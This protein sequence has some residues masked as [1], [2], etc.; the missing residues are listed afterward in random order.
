MNYYEL[1]N[2]EPKASIFEI[3]KAYRN[4]IK[5]YHSDVCLDDTY[6]YQLNEA[7]SVLLDPEKRKLYDLGV[8]KSS[9]KIPQQ[10]TKKHNEIIN[11]Y[12]VWQFKGL[13]VKDSIVDTDFMFKLSKDNYMIIEVKFGCETQEVADYLTEIMTEDFK[14]KNI[15]NEGKYSR[16]IVYSDNMLMFIKF[17][18]VEA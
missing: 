18:G 6:H 12:D 9:T 11:R 13:I 3:K 10:N 16:W 14:A 8:K 2:I 7:A 17:L 15:T 5:K 1:L 4:L